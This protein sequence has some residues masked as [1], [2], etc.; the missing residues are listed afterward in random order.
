M[1]SHSVL[2]VGYVLEI[3]KGSWV[4]TLPKGQASAR[5]GLIFKMPYKS[6]ETIR[7]VRHCEQP[8]QE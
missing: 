8:V 3:G 2:A 6:V 4:L 5:Y 1:C 7:D